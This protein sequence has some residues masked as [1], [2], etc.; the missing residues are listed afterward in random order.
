MATAG[1]QCIL[2]KVLRRN[3]VLLF[4]KVNLS[5][6]LKK[7]NYLWHNISDG[8]AGPRNLTSAL[9]ETSRWMRFGISHGR[10]DSNCT[11]L[12]SR[13]IT[14]VNELVNGKSHDWWMKCTPDLF[15][16]Y[17]TC[18]SN[19]YQIYKR[20]NLAIMSFSLWIIKFIFWNASLKITII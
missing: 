14:V 18:T 11:I 9:W 2:T 1:G 15:N 6:K 16:M 20:W 17:F 4:L 8:S 10:Q 13:R 5:S 12:F 3:I 19:Q 7:H